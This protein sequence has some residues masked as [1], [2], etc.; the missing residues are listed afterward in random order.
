MVSAKQL[1]NRIRQTEFPVLRHEFRMRRNLMERLTAT[2]S[3]AFLG[4]V[5]WILVSA[6]LDLRGRSDNQALFTAFSVIMLFIVCVLVA[7]RSAGMISAERQRHTFDLLA[8]TPLSSRGIITQKTVVA[9]ADAALFVAPTIPTMALIGLRAQLLPVGVAM[10]YVMIASTAFLVA[11][12]GAFWSCM[13]RD[14]RAATFMTYA[15][16]S[17]VLCVPL[18][19]GDL[20]GAAVSMAGSREHPWTPLFVA[21]MLTA[22]AFLVLDS[23]TSK[24]SGK[25]FWGTRTLCTVAIGGGLGFL[26]YLMLSGELNLPTL[27]LQGTLAANVVP[28][29]D[30]IVWEESDAW[31]AAA[32]VVGFS[33]LGATLLLDLSVRR[34]D[35]MRR[36]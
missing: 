11:G 15:S 25:P 12:G 1:V 17:W 14:T 32:A 22:L 33:V 26:A 7:A 27:I 8:L 28:A 6:F 24:A 34:F 31:K 2:P 9:V 4:V 5:A 19:L 29:I 35:A 20:F 23:A 18:I 21:G 13:A 16:A 10:T 36:V 30:G 3:I